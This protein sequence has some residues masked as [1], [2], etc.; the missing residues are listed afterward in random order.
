MRELRLQTK[1]TFQFGFQ[2]FF[3]FAPCNLA[4]EFG[5]FTTVLLRWRGAGYCSELN[6]FAK[7]GQST[8]LG[9]S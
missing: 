8:I 3:V 5:G 1:L 6:N 4:S 9:I 7:K 2:G